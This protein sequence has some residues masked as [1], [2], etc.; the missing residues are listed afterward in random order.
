MDTTC[1]KSRR[2]MNVSKTDWNFIMLRL[3]D[4]VFRTHDLWTSIPFGKTANRDG[5]NKNVKHVTA[6]LRSK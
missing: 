3:K 1:K 4:T 6:C 5:G 2:F